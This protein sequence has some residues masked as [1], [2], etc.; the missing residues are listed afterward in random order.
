[1]KAVNKEFREKIRDTIGYDDTHI[2]ILSRD[3]E[4]YQKEAIESKPE[5]ILWK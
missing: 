1:M 5:K 4:R 3:L 2:E